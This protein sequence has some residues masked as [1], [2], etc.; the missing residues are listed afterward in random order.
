MKVKLWAD[1]ANDFVKLRLPDA[2]AEKRLS[3][4]LVTLRAIEVYLSIYSYQPL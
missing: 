3:S 2:L 1:A 4:D